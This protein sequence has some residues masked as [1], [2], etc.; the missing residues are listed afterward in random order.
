M[1]IATI[2]IFLFCARAG[3]QQAKMIFAVTEKG[4]MS[5]GKK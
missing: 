2:M 1:A 3:Q 5:D 4:E